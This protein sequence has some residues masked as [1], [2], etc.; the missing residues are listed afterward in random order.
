MQRSLYT[1]SP[2]KLFFSLTALAVLGC[3]AGMLISAALS[4]AASQL[5]N[6]AWIPGVSAALTSVSV[7]AVPSL[8]FWHFSTGI[9]RGLQVY[10][11]Q[12]NTLVYASMAVLALQPFLQFIVTF[13]RDF[14]E[15]AL[16]ADI[17]H[18][19]TEAQASREGS[20]ARIVGEHSW[21]SFPVTAL[22]LGIVP[23]LCEE[24]F[25]RGTLQRLLIRISHRKALSVIIVSIVFTAIH[26]D[27]FNCVGIFL[28]SV[29][30]GY[31]YI[32]TSNIWVPVAFHLVSNLWNIF[33]MYAAARIQPEEME[34]TAGLIPWWSALISIV[35]AILLVRMVRTSYLLKRKKHLY[36]K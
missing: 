21:A 4:R 23:A 34:K 35:L 36:G 2:Q 3:L 28:C 27:W 11:P 5:G 13:T 1:Q 15:Y 30:L 14:L 32:Y 29:F 7:F 10:K 31:L 12:W 26:L 22:I 24:F 17:F 8:I 9:K 6:A 18:R 19:L 16:P 20:I 25:F 33:L